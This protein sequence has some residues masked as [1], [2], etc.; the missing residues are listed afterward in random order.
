MTLEELQAQLLATTQELEKT[1]TTLEKEKEKAERVARD[2]ETARTLN[3]QLMAKVVVTNQT[4]EETKE[5]VQKLTPKQI[6]KGGK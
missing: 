6:F 3:G 4:K 1:K 5:E 2:L